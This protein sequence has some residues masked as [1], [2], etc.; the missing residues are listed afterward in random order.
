MHQLGARGYGFASNCCGLAFGEAGKIKTSWHA[1]PGAP[2]TSLP[3]RLREG[4]NVRGHRDL[5]Q[6][7][8]QL[9]GGSIGAGLVLQNSGLQSDQEAPQTHAAQGFDQ[10]SVAPGPRRPG[11]FRSGRAAR[12]GQAVEDMGA[13]GP[14]DHLLPQDRK[15]Q[16]GP[17]LPWQL[18]ERLLVLPIEVRRPLQM[19]AMAIAASVPIGALAHEEEV[20]R[21]GA[22]LRMADAPD[23]DGLGRRLR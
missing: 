11:L 19:R 22:E 20:A 18:V 4:G 16:F 13:P 14:R 15:D 23:I 7:P 1:L 21:P 17:L 6:V 12:A 2:R 8:E 10:M 5:P 3:L 9:L